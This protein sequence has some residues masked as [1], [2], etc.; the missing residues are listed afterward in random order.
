MHQIYYCRSL[1]IKFVNQKHNRIFELGGINETR[2]EI[3]LRFMFLS[4]LFVAC[5]DNMIL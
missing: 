5:I 3:V 4:L 2:F 1:K